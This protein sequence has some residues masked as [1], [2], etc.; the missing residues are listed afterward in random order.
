MPRAYG[1]VTRFARRT[2]D[3]ISTPKIEKIVAR[4]MFTGG[5]IR[6]MRNENGLPMSYGAANVFNKILAKYYAL[7]TSN[8]TLVQF[9]ILEKRSLHREL[10]AARSSEIQAR[11]ERYDR[12][13][14]T[15]ALRGGSTKRLVNPGEFIELPITIKHPHSDRLVSNPSVVKAIS[16][17]YW[18]NLYQ[19]N[20][21]PDIPKPWLTTPS[22]LEIKQRTALDPFLWPRLAS[23]ADFRALLRK[24]TP[25]PAPGRDGWEKWVVKNLPDQVLSIVLKLHNYI[26]ANASFPGKIKDMWL[27]M[28]HKRGL[29]VDLTN[30]RGLLI[31]NFLA[32][33]PMSWL[34]FNLV[35]YVARLRILPDT[36]V[37]TQQ[38]VQTESDV[39]GLQNGLAPAQTGFFGLGLGFWCRAKPKPGRSA[40]KPV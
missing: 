22:V 29:R 24:G 39:F 27:T 12:A 9:A 32:N 23:L 15:N 21:P 6:A 25:R 3:R 31:S 36:Q 8:L 10:Y 7:P 35:P 30:W 5:A 4:L 34:N 17:D 11:K 26:V 13:R 1:R 2:D 28:F 38:G 33:S 18:S 40:C 37:A 19:H 16:H 14:I 20:E